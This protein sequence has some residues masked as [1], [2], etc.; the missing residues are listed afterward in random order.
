M[1]YIGSKNK[2][3][4]HLLPIMLA[5]RGNRAWVEPFV[6][7]ANMIDKIKTGRRIGNDVNANLIALHQAMQN[8][9]IPPDNVSE[10][11]YYEV[12][13][14]KE[15]YFPEIVA[16]VG[17]CCSFSRKYWGGYSKSN[18]GRNSAGE[19]QRNLLKQAENIEDVEFVSID[20]REMVIPDNSLIYCD[21]PYK[22][23]KQYQTTGKFNHDIFW[24]WCRKKKS[25]GHIIFISEYNA[26]NDF[27]CVKEVKR[28]ISL[29][30][31]S[32]SKKVTEK[33]FREKDNV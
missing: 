26:P 31:N 15:K 18:T 13:K 12:K 7:G 11:A 16:F 8:G 4:K 9:W 1:N 33:L 24:D 19:G 17:F 25:E 5:E 6:G 27:E 22:D 10:E 23:I 2:L 29:G 32:N 30:L 14:N 28:T 3:S 20:Y 21:P